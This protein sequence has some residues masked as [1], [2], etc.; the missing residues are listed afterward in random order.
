MSTTKKFIFIPVVNRFDLLQKAVNSVPDNLYDE[1]F[2]FNNSGKNLNDFIDK[3]QFTIINDNQ[4]SFKDTQNKMRL[5]AIE[6][7]YDYYSFMHNDAEILDDT[8]DKLIQK[9]DELINNNAQWGVIFTNYDVFCAFNT[10]CVKN[11][12]EWGDDNWPT[13]KSGYYL[14]VDYYRRMFLLNYLHFYIEHNVSHNE[15]SNTIR[16]ENEFQTWNLQKGHVERHY[17]NKWGGGP[18][19]ETEQVKI[20]FFDPT[21]R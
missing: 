9:A 15:W 1:Y 21:K 12:G 2:I 3:K 11:I 10:N 6:N 13:Q 18:G 17:I 19:Y 5:Y 14:D 16:D 20:I 8:A 4:L 7:N